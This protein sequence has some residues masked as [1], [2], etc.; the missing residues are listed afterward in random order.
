MYTE[1]VD[2]AGNPVP[3]G[4]PGELVA[5]PLGVEGLPLLRYRTG[6]ITCIIPGGCECGRNSPRLGP[7]LARKSQMIKIKGTTLYPLTITNALDEL[8]CL[9]DYVVMLEGDAACAD[10]VTIHAITKPVNIEKISSQV[11][12]KTRISLPI[13]VSNAA[14]IASMRGNGRKK[15]KVVDMRFA[16]RNPK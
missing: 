6:D 1:I 9:E 15:S 12:A 14:T 10:Q 5:T 13:I 2:D 4:T 16:A 3:D 8:D 7:I 11:R